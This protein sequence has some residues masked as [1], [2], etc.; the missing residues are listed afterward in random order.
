[1]I[2][3]WYHYD[4]TNHQADIFKKMKLITR[5]TDYAVRALCFM[6]R[7]QDRERVVSVSQ[8]VKDLKIPRPFLRKLLQVLNKKKILASSRGSEG[9]FTLAR[10]AD[11]IFLT[12]LMRAFQGTFKLNECFFKK[13]RCRNV[14]TCPLRKK[15]MRLEGLVRTE[16]ESITIASLL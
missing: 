15:I 6:A 8:L 13:M 14:R 1:M 5:D 9:G 2:L 16:L 3:L 4:G 12:D 11:K 10:P 7:R